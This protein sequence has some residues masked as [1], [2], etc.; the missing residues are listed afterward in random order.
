M[1]WI[2][3]TPEKCR[4]KDCNHLRCEDCYDCDQDEV[5]LQHCDG[6]IDM[7]PPDLSG[8]IEFHDWNPQPGD[9]RPT[10]PCPLK[11][12]SG[13]DKVFLN[14]EHAAHHAEI[15]DPVTPNSCPF[16]GCDRQF[17]REDDEALHL[18]THTA[19]VLILC[20]FHD[21]DL[22]FGT[23]DAKTPHLII[24]FSEKKTPLCD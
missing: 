3:N 18:L 6:A 17:A 21:C 10:F 9:T 2:F 23:E 5:R 24:H 8:A 11:E 16:P 1:R 19:P 14:S 12:K 20:P 15:H 22:K 7:N 13:C 4:T